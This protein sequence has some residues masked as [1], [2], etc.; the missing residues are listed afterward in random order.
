MRPTTVTETQAGAAT[1]EEE[2]SAD[3]EDVGFRISGTVRDS[4]SG[5]S[6]ANAL[7]IAHRQWTSA[8]E[9]T[10]QQENVAAIESG[11]NE[12]MGELLEQKRA[13]TLRRNGKAGANGSFSINIVSEGAYILTGNLANYIAIEGRPVYLS[14]EERMVV[15]D[16]KMSRGATISG[17]VIELGSAR[18]AEGVT[19]I[20]KFADAKTDDQGNYTLSGLEP[21]EY[22]VSIN[23]KDVAYAPG[24]VLPFK[25]VTLQNPDEE[26]RNVN[27]EIEPAGLV[28]GY[29]YT[30]DR[31]PIN[32]ASLVLGGMQSVVSQAINA[33][34]RETPPL[35][36]RSNNEGYYELIG[37]PLN[38]EMQVYATS[39]DHAPQLADPFVLTARHR[40][41]H[42]DIFMFPGSAIY[43][44]VVDS[45][46]T[47]IQDAQVLL[48]PSYQK[49]FSPLDTP[50]AL[51]GSSS[52][53][54]GTFVLKE[55]PAG[56]YQL[57]AMR[58]G[59]KYSAIGQ[60]IYPD[61][62]HD[63]TGVRVILSAVGD[64]AH[65]I[66]GTVKDSGGSTIGGA[67]IQLG[68]LSTEAFGPVSD[69]TVTDNSGEFVFEG[70]DAGTYQ[71]TV[72]ASGYATETVARVLLDEETNVTL[73]AA[74]QVNGR[75]LVR[76]LNQPPSQYSVSAS[77]IR[78]DND[79]TL[80]LDAF[81]AGAPSKTFNASDGSFT[82]E[83]RP[84]FYKL[85]A[86]ASDYTPGRTDISLE[87][88][89]VLSGITIYVSESGGRIEGRVQTSDGGNPQG[90]V[91][92]LAEPNLSP[93]FFSSIAGLGSEN[94]T[95]VGEDGVFVFEKLPAGEYLVTADHEHYTPVTH[96]PVIL[97]E[98][99][100]ASGIV[101]RLSTGG[102][103]EGYV[104]QNGQVVPGAII[105][106]DVVGR[107]HFTT[108]DD[109]GFYRLENLP[110]GKRQIRLTLTGI[111]GSLSAASEVSSAQ[112]TDGQTT[113]HN[114]GDVPGTSIVGQ[115]SQPPIELSDLP[116]G[117]VVHGAPGTGL[118]LYGDTFTLRDYDQIRTQ[119]PNVTSIGPDGVFMISDVTPGEWQLSFLFLEG[120]SLRVVH[121]KLVTITGE[122]QELNLGVIEVN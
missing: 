31:K 46:L 32:G 4:R 72:T 112:I 78:D 101:L 79:P 20:T 73:D 24:P 58:E 28:W 30:P 87:P 61:G 36:D 5:E 94:Q 107:P 97:Q 93:E 38:Q 88:D 95:Q 45:G 33:V 103:V 83:L 85:E 23:L 118:P 114:F 105:T 66:F 15:A 62:F 10:W 108:T 41:A 76:E 80:G 86:R 51:R 11:D 14:E 25:R 21:G 104:Y 91:V 90:A 122:E 110:S 65:T 44:R 17:R 18:G 74:S 120:M 3:T 106:L 47:P 64:G 75:V 40:T 1:E 16:V 8:E 81:I 43:G 115:F 116:G 82:L 52:E 49:L 34:M 102:A 13:L 92:S 60:P 54:D 9:E 69:E 35:S 59:Y 12:R 42:I 53:E 29:V 109:N 96:G 68:G 57:L 55:I 121:S 119:F 70:I 39:E 113:Q 67:E 7:V 50:Q 27:F 6:L 111:G 22:E 63:I 89:Q 100:N 26:M 84:G 99:G 56:N 48:L 117:F 2:V 19:V 37:V 77:P 71:L 98:N